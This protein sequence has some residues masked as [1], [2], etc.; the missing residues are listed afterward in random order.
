LG[1]GIGA[2]V[3]VGA[4]AGG[5]SSVM[6]GGDFAEGAIQGAWT[7][8]A[9]FAFNHGLHHGPVGSL[10]RFF[11]FIISKPFTFQLG[12]GFNMGFGFG[13]SSASGLAIS[14][15]PE[16]GEGEWGFYMTKALG[17]QAGAIIE[18][19][20]DISVSPNSSISDLE[21]LSFI[22]GGSGGSFLPRIGA[23]GE[24]AIPIFPTE[25]Y[26]T[27]TGTISSGLS[28][29]PVEVHGLV[30]RTRVFQVGKW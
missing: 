11:N 9:A 28:Y 25:T 12:L 8:A 27:V 26:P 6:S 1:G 30:G 21:G 13:A 29:W 2:R 7:S 18:G 23:G 15:N 19:A 14:Y 24:V 20:L 16:T 4:A 22:A 3:G 10:K 17:V 5:M